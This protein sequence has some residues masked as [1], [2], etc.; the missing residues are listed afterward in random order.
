M[1]YLQ[2]QDFL[3]AKGMDETPAIPASSSLEQSWYQKGS[4][5]FF[6]GCAAGT[7]FERFVGWRGQNGRDRSI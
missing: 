5:L 6:I 4:I 3:H 2:D 7:L 1:I